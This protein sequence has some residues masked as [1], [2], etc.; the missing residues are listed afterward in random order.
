[1]DPSTETLVGAG[2]DVK[3]LLGIV[4]HG[5]GFR[6][7]ED[8]IGGLAVG[9]RFSHCAL[10]TGKLSGGDDLHGFCD[11]FNVADGF[12]AAFDFAEGCVGGGIG[13]K[14]AS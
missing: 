6:F 10:G 2:N 13:D 1:M 4:F 3:R 7:F 9:A 8:G 5:F 14:R 12:E 11:F